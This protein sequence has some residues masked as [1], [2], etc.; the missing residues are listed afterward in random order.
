[1]RGIILRV[2]MSLRPKEEV[3]ICYRLKIPHP[4]ISGFALNTLEGTIGALHGMTR[5]IEIIPDFPADCPFKFEC[6]ENSGIIPMRSAS[7]IISNP[8]IP[9]LD[10]STNASRVVSL[11]LSGCHYHLRFNEP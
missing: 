7:G 11:A 8:D 6:H 10:N 2:L 3:L 5:F 1:M 4:D 9:G